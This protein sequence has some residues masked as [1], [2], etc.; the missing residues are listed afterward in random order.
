MFRTAKNAIEIYDVM[1]MHTQWSHLVVKNGQI[2][3]KFAM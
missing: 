3:L 1:T 2:D